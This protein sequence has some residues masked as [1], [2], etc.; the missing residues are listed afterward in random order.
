MKSVL[1]I[2]TVLLVSSCSTF[3]FPGVHRIS[4]Q[5]GNVISQSM[6]DKLKPGMTK[7]QVRFVLG[8]PV[9][10]DS[11]DQDQWDYIHTFHIA[12]G[13]VIRQKLAL[14]FRED[15]LSYFEGDFLPSDRSDL[16]EAEAN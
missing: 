14:H 8:N 10:D 1:L 13:D 7:S 2:S 16:L 6:I 12:G 4:I 15:R 3:R 5:Q 9:I 11:L